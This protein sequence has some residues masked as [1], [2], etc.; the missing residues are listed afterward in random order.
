MG[1]S[2]TQDEEDDAVCAE[3]EEVIP[4]AEH[5]YWCDG[6]YAD[7]CE[8]CVKLCDDCASE[9]FVYRMCSQCL[10]HYQHHIS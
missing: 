7:L 5:D 1:Y 4:A 6:C 10:D 2:V 9:G 8:D 3:C